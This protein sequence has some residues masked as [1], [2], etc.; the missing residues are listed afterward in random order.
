MGLLS[1]LDIAKLTDMQMLHA[2]LALPGK[3]LPG[4]PRQYSNVILPGH[5]PVVVQGAAGL[6]IKQYYDAYE[7]NLCANYFV[8]RRATVLR[9][10]VTEACT[11][12][13]FAIENAPVVFSSNAPSAGGIPVTEGTMVKLKFGGPSNTHYVSFNKGTYCTVH[14]AVPD[15]FAYL[16]KNEKWIYNTLDHYD[17]VVCK[18]HRD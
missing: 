1:T 2:D 11:V 4:I 14:L 13:F 18:T 7:Y 15:R 6:L 5:D 17:A 10:N 9:L 8:F 16:L 3:Q 12:Y